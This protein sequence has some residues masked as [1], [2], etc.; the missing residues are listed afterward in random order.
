MERERERGG[1]RGMSNGGRST[2]Q[3]RDKDMLSMTGKHGGS[4][5]TRVVLRNR[6]AEPSRETETERNVEQR[7]REG[8]MERIVKNRR[9]QQAV[10]GREWKFQLYFNNLLNN[11]YF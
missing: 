5:W 6:R 11:K 7:D 9:G 1:M 8:D 4:E 3:W 2:Y 10:K